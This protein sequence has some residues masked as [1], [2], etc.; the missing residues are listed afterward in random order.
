MKTF[1][2]ILVFTC[3]CSLLICGKAGAQAK[4]TTAIKGTYRNIYEMLKDVPGLDVTSN[5]GRGGKITVRGLTSLT[6]QG[7]PIFVIDGSVYSGDIADLNPED[8]ESVSVLKDAASQ[9]AY[10]SRA[11]FGV[12]VVT[13]KNGKG[14]STLNSAAVSNFSGSAYA[15][16]FEHKTKLK[17]FD[18]DEKVIVEG[19]IQQL[20]DSL[21]VFK[22]RKTEILVPIKNIKRVEM[23]PADD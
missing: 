19:V 20:R 11:M 12:I 21:L 14:V 7:Q 18:Q 13:S 1:K 23:M 22:K 5:N 8:I 6:Q 16:F 15:Y 17:V 4:S 10:G 3:F 9:T 2:Q